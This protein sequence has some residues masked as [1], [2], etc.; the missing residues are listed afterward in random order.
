[1]RILFVLPGGRRDYFGEE[2]LPVKKLRGLE[3]RFRRSERPR[4]FYGPLDVTA[5]GPVVRPSRGKLPPAAQLCVKL[6][7][8]ARWRLAHE[9]PFVVPGPVAPEAISRRAVAKA[10]QRGLLAGL[11]P[12]QLAEQIRSAEWVNVR[13][14]VPQ[15]RGALPTYF[16][17][18][19]L[20]PLRA[21]LPQL[22]LAGRPLVPLMFGVRQAELD[23]ALA[24]NNEVAIRL[25]NRV[26]ERFPGLTEDEV[27]ALLCGEDVVITPEQLSRESRFAKALPVP[28]DKVEGG[29]ATWK[30]LRM[31]FRVD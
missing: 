6:T 13:Y 4:F 3:F 23:R 8:G 14:L 31:P 19:A 29:L 24:G 22:R 7:F 28:P 25:I 16:H 18:D 27:A 12:D 15:L 5:E 11:E 20:Q 2:Y 21:P 1:M 30:G 10:A 17:R 9:H 26:R